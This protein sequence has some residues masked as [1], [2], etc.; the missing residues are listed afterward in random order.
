MVL[1][2][3]VFISLLKYPFFLFIRSTFSFTSLNMDIR[4]AIFYMSCILNCI[5]EILLIQF[6][7]DRFFHVPLN[8][9]DFFAFRRQWTWL[10][11]NIQLCLPCG[12]QMLKSLPLLLALAVLLALCLACVAHLIQESTRILCRYYI[13]SLGI[14]FYVSLF[15]K[16]LTFTFQLLWFPKLCPLTY[17]TSKLWHFIWVLD[18]QYYVWNL[19]LKEKP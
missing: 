1:F 6:I 16:M 9:V 13:Q 18:A 10:N 4:A 11:S 8:S 5:I 12:R 15:P 7:D 3:V 19:S 14:P 17:Y 2:Y